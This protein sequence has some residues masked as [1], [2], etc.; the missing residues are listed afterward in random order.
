M[1]RD[2]SDENIQRLKNGLQV[3]GDA[4]DTLAERPAPAQ[5]AIADRSLSGDKIDGG[6]IRRFASTGIRDDSTRLTVLINDDGILTDH[7]D[8]AKLKGDTTVEGNL[9]VEGAV[10]AQRLHVNEI[11]AD[12]R[13]ERTSPLIFEQTEDNPI[14]GKGLHFVGEGHTRQLVFHI[15]PD[16]FFM[17][18]N[19]DLHKGKYISIEGRKVLDG[20]SL[21]EGVRH[22][23]L[24]TVGRLKNLSTTG[25]TVIDGMI[26]WNSDQERLGIRTDTPNGM[27]SLAGNDAELIMDAENDSFKIGTW[28]ANDLKIVTDDT[29]RLTVSATG[30]IVLGTKGNDSTKVNIYGKL[31]VGVNN[32]DPDVSIQASGPIKFADK[33]FEVGHN[34]PVQ[35]TYKRGDIVWNDEP[36]PNAPVGWICITEGTPGDWRPF[37]KIYT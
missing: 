36:A 27:L 32:I 12:V 21:G 22:S 10:T 8:V 33:K 20:Q 2:I 19:L 1:A 37:G 5:A 14:A 16:R 25:D 9:T 6:K 28:T 3:L 13:Q 26:F 24:T 30:N 35:G 17:S 11:T 7:I 29:A 34:Y 23:A 18:E 31:G 4:I 15:N